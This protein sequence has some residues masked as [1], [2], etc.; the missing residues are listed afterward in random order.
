MVASGR[1]NHTRVQDHDFRSQCSLAGLQDRLPLRWPTLF[2]FPPSPKRRYRS[3]YRYL[4]WKELQDPEAWRHLSDFDL[5]LR[6]VDFSPLRPVLAKRLGWTSAKGWPPFDPVSIFLLL[7]WQ[8]NEGWNRSQLLANLQDPRY[9]DYAARFGFHNGVFPT[10]GGLRHWLTALGQ[11]AEN[12]DTVSVGEEEQIEVAVQYL[13]QLL[14]QT[15]ALLHE[16]GLVTPAAWDQALICPDGMLHDAASRLRCI[17]VAETCYQPT[18][19]QAPRPCP[20]KQ[21]DRHGCNCDTPSC[22]LLCRHATPRDPDARFVW[23]TGSNRQPNHPNAFTDPRRT[24]RPRGKGRYGYATLPLLLAEPSRRFH[25]VLLDDFCPANQRLENAFAAQLRQLDTFYPTLHV[26]AVAGDAAF[27]YEIVLHT[28]YDH[29]Q[30]RRVIDLRADESDRNLSLWPLR[31][32]DDR[33]RPICPFGYALS[34]NGFDYQRRRHKWACFHACQKGVP[35][36]V[37][38]PDVPYPPTVCPHMKRPS[39]QLLNVGE[40]F[41]DGSIRLVRDLPVGSS[42]WKSLYHQARN[43]SESRNAVFQRW[44]LKRFPVYGSMRAKALAFL[45]DVW[46]NLTTLVRLIREATAATGAT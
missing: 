38:V 28:V 3:R 4:G 40:R 27:G 30:A 31:G 46:I 15:V 20:A 6:L 22:Q 19:A 42:A 44:S 12:G 7:G 10:E 43:A 9:A 39:G 5:L 26:D 16:A 45:A 34:A 41:P 13:N 37:V 14:A 36:R 8:L 25:L 11:H 21:R 1:P 17:S 32:Y 23:Y 18:S 33:G 35:P 24:S 2:S 29:L